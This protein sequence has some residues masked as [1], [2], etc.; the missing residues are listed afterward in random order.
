MLDGFEESLQSRCPVLPGQVTKYDNSTCP[1]DVMDDDDEQE[2]QAN[3]TNM[4][5]RRG[6]GHPLHARTKRPLLKKLLKQ[7]LK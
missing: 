3:T 1:L 7:E 6:R 4:A 5:D 2:Q